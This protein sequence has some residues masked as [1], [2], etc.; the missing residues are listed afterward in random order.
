[1]T[2]WAFH[3]AAVFGSALMAC[4]LALEHPSGAAEPRFHVLQTVP[5]GTPPLADFTLP[6]LEGKPRRLS[7]W[8]GK[9]V[10]LAFFATWCPLCNEEMP[11]LSE[12]QKSY[13]ARGFSVLAVSIDQVGAGPVGRWT[14]ERGLV[15]P[16][17]QDKSFSS[18]A[19]HGV[20]FVPTL[21]LLDRE[22]RLA[23]RAVGSVDWQGREASD[24]I[25]RLLAPPLAA[26]RVG[27]P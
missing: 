13:E 2:V 5:P 15:F 27:A 7:E 9:V 21:Y 12:L 6:D 24:L 18:R 1:M 19:T 26:R 10:L 25:E 22:M 16:I 14:Q 4:F 17:L 3:R 8:R 11:R 23:A 20:R